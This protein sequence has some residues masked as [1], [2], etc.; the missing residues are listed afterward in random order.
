MRRQTQSSSWQSDR[1]PSIRI[2]QQVLA[3]RPDL[4]LNPSSVRFA[5]AASVTTTVDVI[6][7]VLHLPNITRQR[8]DRPQKEN[9]WSHRNPRN[10]EALGRVTIKKLFCYLSLLHV[11]VPLLLRRIC[12][13]NRRD[14]LL[15]CCHRGDRR[16]VA[17]SVI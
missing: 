1:F 9:A 14:K 2:L 5:H 15:I 3:A 16:D 13:H 10:H 4:S 11:E 7:E 17:I 6:L 12:S 8:Q